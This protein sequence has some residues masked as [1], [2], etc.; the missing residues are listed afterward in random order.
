MWL[1]SLR[2]L[3]RSEI[4]TEDLVIAHNIPKTK[5]LQGTKDQHKY[6]GPYKTNFVAKSHLNA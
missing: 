5:K 3:F 2:I 4:D 1:N 6:L